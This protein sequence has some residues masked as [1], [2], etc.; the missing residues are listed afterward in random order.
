MT[1][2]QHNNVLNKGLKHL[3]QSS[4]WK[5][6]S[7][8]IQEINQRNPYDDPHQRL[9]WVEQCAVNFPILYLSCLYVYVWAK[10]THC[11]NFLFASRDCCHM[12]KI[13]KK[14]FPNENSHY[15]NCSRN[16]FEISTEKPRENTTFHNYVK[17]LTNGNINET[18]YIDIHGTGQRVFSYFQKQFGEIPYCLLL[19]ATHNS[20]K[21]FPSISRPHGNNKLINLAF[22][23]RGGPIESLNYDQ[24]GTLQAYDA[25]KGPIRDVLEYD[26]K[27]IEPY[28]NCMQTITK[29]L[30]KLDLQTVM[31]KYSLNDL[32]Q[33]IVNFFKFIQKDYPIISKNFSHVGKHKKNKHKNK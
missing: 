24:I 7:N 29:H 16:M 19:S 26:I 22:N 8:A 14:M 18:I 4:K 31:T 25:I 6:L 28:H 13:F 27:T 5:G 23:I 15:F 9:M 20:Y 30:V 12:A 32:N 33:M 3:S 2:I 21:D 17:S 11:K 10:Q 1:L